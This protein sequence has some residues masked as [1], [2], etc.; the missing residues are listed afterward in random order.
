M[1]CGCRRIESQNQEVYSSILF[2]WSEFEYHSMMHNRRIKILCFVQ[3][4]A[5]CYFY[6]FSKTLMLLFLSW[7]RRFKSLFRFGKT[8]FLVLV[9]SIRIRCDELRW[10]CLRSF[11]CLCAHDVVR[12]SKKKRL[13]GVFRFIRFLQPS[14]Q[15]RK[16]FLWQFFFSSS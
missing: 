16:W 8:F 14:T 10:V 12:P 3:T 2:D 5:L 11:V 6:S 15:L 1:F 7:D 4:S 13:V 9:P